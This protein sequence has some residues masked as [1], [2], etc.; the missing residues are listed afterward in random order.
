VRS[1]VSDPGNELR[2]QMFATFTVHLGSATRAPAVP[3]DAVVREGD[4]TMSVWV[5][6]DRRLFTRRTVNIG[7]QQGGFDQV[8]TGVKSGELIAATGALFISNASIQGAA[9]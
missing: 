6:A 7:Q 2:A 1:Q 3:V 4:G 5:T 9:D 8:V